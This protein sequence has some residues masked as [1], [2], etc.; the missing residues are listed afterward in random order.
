MHE[1][2]SLYLVNITNSTLKHKKHYLNNEYIS[3][4]SFCIGVPVKAHLKPALSLDT[5]RD[6][7]LL[8]FFM[9][10]ASSRTI[11]SQAI[12]IMFGMNFFCFISPC[13]KIISWIRVARRE[14]SQYQT[15]NMKHQVK[16]IWQKKRIKIIGLFGIIKQINKNVNLFNENS[17]KSRKEVNYKRAIM[18]LFC[19]P[20]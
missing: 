4:R 2:F 10:C 15:D 6:C 13:L 20:E 18:T 12:R 3:S 8:W 16:H 19:S 9:L 7:K 1:Y 11:R 14:F 5:A 17:W